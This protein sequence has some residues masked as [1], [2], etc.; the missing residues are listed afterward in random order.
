MTVEKCYL[1]LKRRSYMM[2]AQHNE[3]TCAPVELLVEGHVLKKLQRCTK[4]NFINFTSGVLQHVQQYHAGITKCSSRNV[5]LF[6]LKQMVFG[7][8][9]RQFG[10]K[11]YGILVKQTMIKHTVLVEIEHCSVHLLSHASIA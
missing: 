7:L 3:V 4:P 10:C 2:R 1:V 9:G 11:L 6:R 5:F 8:I